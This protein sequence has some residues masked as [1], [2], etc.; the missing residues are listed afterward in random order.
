M[1]HVPVRRMATV[2]VRLPAEGY[3]AARITRLFKTVGDPVRRDELVATLDTMKCS[4]DMHAPCAGR[5]MGV[6]AQE[7]GCVEFGQ[8]VL[9]ID[10]PE[11]TPAV[12]PSTQPASPPS[13][14]R[15]SSSRWWRRWLGG[16]ARQ[17]STSTSSNPPPAPPH[18]APEDPTA[19]FLR[20]LAESKTVVES[21]AVN[22]RIKG[23][24]LIVKLPDLALT[25][26]RFGPQVTFPE[27]LFMDFN[28][29]TFTPEDMCDGHNHEVWALRRTTVPLA[30]R[31]FQRYTSDKQGYS[32]TMELS[33]IFCN[34]MPSHD[35]LA[36]MEKEEGSGEGVSFWPD[37]LLTAYDTEDAA[38]ESGIGQGERQLLLGAVGG[39]N[40][41][42]DAFYKFLLLSYDTVPKQGFIGTYHML[43]QA[44]VPHFGIILKW[45]LRI[46]RNDQK[47]ISFHAAHGFRETFADA[48]A[49]LRPQIYAPQVN[50][51]KSHYHL[52]R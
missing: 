51:S 15:S 11:P 34:R 41:S 10:A 27:S 33:A 24:D 45:H 43:T 36:R 20:D 46:S 1:G 30:E 29:W 16:G 7:G 4:I 48:F 14:Q 13:T 32:Q 5:L 39:A 23:G 3:G 31:C 42:K 18:S 47:P 26:C 50:A 2:S 40:S 6:A 25:S 38:L 49:K 21:N 22:P 44:I 17:F 28:G 9:Q 52:V 35:F 19:S 12:P 8:E 37:K